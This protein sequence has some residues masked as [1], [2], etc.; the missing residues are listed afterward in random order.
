MAGPATTGELAALLRQASPFVWRAARQA[1]PHEQDALDARALMP[2]VEETLAR[3]PQPELTVSG[4]GLRVDARPQRSAS[5]S[6]AQA[7]TEAW[8]QVTAAR[9]ATPQGSSTAAV[10]GLLRGI[11][12]GRPIKPWHEIAVIVATPNGPAS[13]AVR[14]RVWIRDHVAP[15][16]PNIAG[17]AADKQ[18]QEIIADFREGTH[19]WN[20][21]IRERVQTLAA[22]LPAHGFDLELGTGIPVGPYWGGQHGWQTWRDHAGVVG[23]YVLAATGDDQLWGLADMHGIAQWVRLLSTPHPEHVGFLINPRDLVIA[24]Q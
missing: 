15:I 14:A 11:I 9:A 8:A 16:W 13:A 17:F 3:A 21:N 23:A 19:G 10:V 4:D 20:P 7:S 24:T 18:A 22:S 5:A 2:R 6:D 12:R 1:K